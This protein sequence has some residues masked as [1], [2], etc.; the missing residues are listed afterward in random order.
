MRNTV[1][2]I[3][4]I[5]IFAALVV[6]PAHAQMLPTTQPGPHA[7]QISGV[8]DK[9]GQ[10]IFGVRFIEINGR[11]ITPRSVIWL[12]PGSYT[13][14]VLIDAAH[15]RRPPQFRG[16]REHRRDPGY[17]EIELELEAGKTYEIRARYDRDNR[18]AP[19]SVILYRIH[20]VSG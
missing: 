16:H 4:A 12:E 1:L 14:K 17:N 11:N 18:D 6:A 8:L 2:S 3:T 13:L 7:A 5:L 10:E 9:A 15:F 19:Y 20:P